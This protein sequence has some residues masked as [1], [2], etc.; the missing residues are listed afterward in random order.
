MMVQGSG[1]EMSDELPGPP[2]A[3][4]LRRLA[5][6]AVDT[7]RV[8]TDALGALPTASSPV[9]HAIRAMIEG[10]EIGLIGQV[11]QLEETQPGPPEPPE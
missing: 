5:A 1:D 11:A 10:V 8:E 2:A 9:G 3:A 4:A 7:A 6:A